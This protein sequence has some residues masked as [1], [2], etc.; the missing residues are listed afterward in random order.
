MR[1]FMGGP[2]RAHQFLYLGLVAALTLAAPSVWARGLNPSDLPVAQAELR[3][4]ILGVFTVL[5]PLAVWIA[6]V[7]ARALTNPLRADVPPSESVMD[8]E[9]PF[10]GPAAESGEAG[11]PRCAVVLAPGAGEAIAHITSAVEGL[12][13]QAHVLALNAVVEAT[14]A[15]DQGQGFSLVAGDVRQLAQR[16]AEA[17]KQL[18]KLTPASV[19]SAAQDPAVPQA[20][21]TMQ[22]VV[23]SIRRVTEASWQKSSASPQDGARR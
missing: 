1:D 22:Q 16:T 15:G 12:A 6:L 17:A 18:R 21:E 20:N 8:A 2:Q 3:G 4:M 23:A 9:R 7:A 13:F 11:P 19:E 14:R 5:L 10:D